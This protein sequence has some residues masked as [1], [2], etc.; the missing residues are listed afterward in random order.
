MVA[1]RG[2][3]KVW[4]LHQ[5]VWIRQSGCMGNSC[6]LPT[7]KG[8]GEASSSC[9][10]VLLA[11]SLGLGL[12]GCMVGPDFVPP[13][14][15]PVAGYLPDARPGSSA[16]GQKI[17]H[18]G[19]V[20]DSWWTLFKSSRLNEL[21]AGGLAHNPDVKA[22]EAAIRVASHLARA[23]RGELFPAIDANYNV[24]REKVP[25]QTRTSD[26]ASGASI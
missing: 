13:P 12:S 11:A 15:P 19:R 23:Q 3:R 8:T 10:L 17:V 21:V 9:R 1:H 4:H 16:G 5:Y 7:N 24:T 14:P 18:G 26:A 2:Q 25:T 20:P 6:R 22:Q